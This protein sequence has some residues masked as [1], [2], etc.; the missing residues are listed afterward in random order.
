MATQEGPVDAPVQSLISRWGLPTAGLLPTR[1][2]TAGLS[3]LLVH[4]PEGIP[5]VGAQIAA[6][7]RKA[8]QGDSHRSDPK[9]SALGPSPKGTPQ[10]PAARVMAPRTKDGHDCTN[11][12]AS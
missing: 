2:S 6:P 11:H 1:T 7:R 10:G 5:A 9:K 12:T 3:H 8:N 4:C